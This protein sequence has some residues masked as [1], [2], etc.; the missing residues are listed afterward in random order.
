[1]SYRQWQK[2]NTDAFCKLSKNQQQAARQQGYFNIGWQ[3]VQQSWSILQ[4][5]TEPPNLLNAKLK[6]GDLAGAVNQSILEA[7]QAQQI[8][9]QGIS[10]LE[11]SCKQVKRLAKTTL[12][13]YQL[14]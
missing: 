3:K 10:D 7:E 1:M 2:R 4:L 6:K 14:L 8:A 5:I 9:R 11:R 12:N 13:E